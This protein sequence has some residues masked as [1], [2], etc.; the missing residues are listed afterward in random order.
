MKF[1]LKSLF[2]WEIF[3][4]MSKP[5]STWYQITVFYISYQ[6]ILFSS[7]SV[8]MKNERSAPIEKLCLTFL[9]FDRN[10]LSY[11]RNILYFYNN[12]KVY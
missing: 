7:Y 1:G 9:E 8:F 4:N 6:N 12:Y 5:C 10:F 11:W 3:Y 2:S